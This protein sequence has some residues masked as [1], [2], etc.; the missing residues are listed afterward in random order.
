MAATILVP[1]IATP[2]GLRLIVVGTWMTHATRRSPHVS[3]QGETIMTRLVPVGLAAASLCA[4]LVLASS[5][6]AVAPRR[7][8]ATSLSPRQVEQLYRDRTWLWKD[9]AGYF[10][11]DGS[12]VAWSGSRPP[13]AS[14]ARGRWYAADPGRICFEATWHAGS[15]TNARTT[16]FGHRMLGRT[17]Q[18]RKEPSGPWYGFRQ[19][20]PRD[21]FRKLVR[22]DRASDRAKRIE[23]ALARTPPKPVADQPMAEP[24]EQVPATG[25]TRLP[26]G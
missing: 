1:C 8:P 5:A 3:T 17:I 21:E 16:C 26:R 13:N 4:S 6:E 12:F 2:H 23:A 20:G 9:G 7:A 25:S 24:T 18:Q 15:G 11:P 19:G 14:Y 10:A 22:G